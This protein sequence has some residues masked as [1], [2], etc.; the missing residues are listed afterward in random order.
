VKNNSS[1]AIV[2]F[3]VLRSLRIALGN[4]VPGPAFKAGLRSGDKILS[5]DDAAVTNF[6]QVS[7]AVMLGNRK[8]SQGNPTATFKVERG[9]ETLEIV[10]QPARL[11][12]NSQSGDKVRVAGIQ[13]RTAVIVGT[14]APGSPASSRPW[15]PRPHPLHRRSAA[16]QHR[17]VPRDPPQ[18]RRQAA[19]APDRAGRRRLQGRHHPADD[20]DRQP[21]RRHRPTAKTAATRSSWSPR[22]A[23]SSPRTLRPCA[24]S[25]IV[26]G[27]S[28]DDPAL[29]ETLKI[30]TIVDMV[31]GRDQLVF[32]VR[33][34]DGLA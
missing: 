16:E 32:S 8:D 21:G 28:P 27:V 5:V 7:E 12:V 26:L 23:I 13:P 3:G 25:F 17:R 19:H 34:I 15:N 11:E 9:G 29:A 6:N 1:I 30:G 10:V 24:T 33:S 20:D 2:T 31:D 14:P 4:T 22:R 18:G